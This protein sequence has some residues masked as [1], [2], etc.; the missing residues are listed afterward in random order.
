MYSHSSFLVC[1]SFLSFIPSSFLSHPNPVFANFALCAL[2]PSRI[3]RCLIFLSSYSFHSFLIPFRSSSSSIDR[4]VDAGQTAPGA[5]WSGGQVLVCH[6]RR[7]GDKTVAS[8]KSAVHDG[9]CP[10]RRQTV[11]HPT[12]QGHHHRCFEDGARSSSSSGCAFAA[13]EAFYKHPHPLR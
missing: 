10:V 1:W 9:N 6:C 7:D 4:F 13:S 3:P 5:T 12:S 2:L 8:R 11:V